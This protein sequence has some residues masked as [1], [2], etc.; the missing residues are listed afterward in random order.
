MTGKQLNEE[1]RALLARCF[2]VKKLTNAEIA[3]ILNVSIT[4]IQRRRIEY[5]KTGVLKPHRDVSKNAEKLKPH[6]LEVDLFSQK[7]VEWH[8]DHPDALLYDMQLFLRVHCGVNLSTSTISRQFRKAIGVTSRL[9][10]TK[11]RIMSRRR[12][13]AEGRSLADEI[14]QGA[15]ATAAGV[16]SGS[17]SANGSRSSSAGVSGSSGNGGVQTVVGQ[18][19]GQEQQQQQQQRVL[20]PIPQPVA[21]REGGQA[22]HQGYGQQTAA[23]QSYRMEYFARPP[24]EPAHQG[25][26]QQQTCR[27]ASDQ[28]EYVYTTTGNTR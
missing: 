10:G 1:Q 7:L 14:H 15:Q 26:R 17:V 23:H 4:T 2:Q 13:E 6:H 21:A 18:Q 22:H 16:S 8:K 12:R 20:P 27:L 19:Q 9:S 24:S 5:E 11:A 3:F 28:Q 25:D